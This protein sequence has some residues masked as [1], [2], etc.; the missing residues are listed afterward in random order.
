MEKLFKLV[1]YFKNQEGRTTSIT[2]RN[3]K[4][5]LPPAVVE[6]AMNAVVSTAIFS[7]QGGRLVTAVGAELVEES[8]TGI[9]ITL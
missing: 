3:C 1:M 7:S 6:A 9:E 5:V 8:K 4:E 2:L